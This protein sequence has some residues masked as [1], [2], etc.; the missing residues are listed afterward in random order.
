MEKKYW[1]NE[2]A[3]VTETKYAEVHYYKEAGKIQ[4]YGTYKKSDGSFGRT[5]AAVWDNNEMEADDVVKLAYAV[6]RGLVDVGIENDAFTEAYEILS[7]AVG[8]VSD[9]DEETTEVLD[10]EFEDEEDESESV[11]YEDMTVAELKTECQSR[12]IA[13]PKRAVKSKLIQLLQAYDNR[14]T[15]TGKATDMDFKKAL[16]SNNL[17]YIGKH[18]I[19]DG[20]DIDPKKTD[21]VGYRKASKKVK[22]VYMEYMD[23]C[24]EWVTYIIERSKALT[25]MPTKTQVQ[26]KKQ[27]KAYGVLKEEIADWVDSWDEVATEGEVSAISDIA[28]GLMYASV[29]EVEAM[30]MLAKIID[31]I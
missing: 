16:D 23:D 4:L 10:E 17:M 30:V 21:Y 15:S 20:K 26:K 11:N 29:G 22:K 31:K 5:K 12:E 19:Y 6:M 1:E 8:E 28:N 25:L 24:N 18:I 2:E 14:T 27:D 7:N 9:E 13:I 3:I